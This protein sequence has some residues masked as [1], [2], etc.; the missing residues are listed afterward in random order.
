MMATLLERL[1]ARRDET[2]FTLVELLVGIVLFGVISTM[3]F[4][5]VMTAAGSVRNSRDYNDLN[6]EARVMLNR[7]SREIREAK[8]IVAV[9]SPGTKTGFDPVN[10]A[11]SFTFDVDFNRNGTIEPD[12]LDPEELTYRYDPTAHRV[13]LQAAG[14]TYPILADNVSSFRLDYTSR[15]YAYDGADGSVKDG[16]VNWWELDADTTGA[17][18]NH[19]GALD[20]ELTSVDSVTITFT[21]LKGIRQQTYRTQ[22]DLRNRPY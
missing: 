19:N 9:T 10:T 17:V 12:A 20:Q 8:A 14:L 5:S 13:L 21:V 18:G 4:M 1:E 22:I 16:Q 6:E 7:M 2:G 15:L 11:Q 3:L